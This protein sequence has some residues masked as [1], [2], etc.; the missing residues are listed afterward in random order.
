MIKALILAVIGYLF[1]PVIIILLT[2]LASLI[3][4]LAGWL[5]Q[6]PGIPS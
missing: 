6:I 3:L 2:I 1:L 4:M 5:T